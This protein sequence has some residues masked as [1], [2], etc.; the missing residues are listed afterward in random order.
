MTSDSMRRHADLSALLCGRENRSRLVRARAVRG[1]GAGDLAGR[2]HDGVDAV[3]TLHLAVVYEP[4]GLR[5]RGLAQAE[6]GVP[7]PTGV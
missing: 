2:H 1:A 4:P 3:V 5:Q 6:H 7:A